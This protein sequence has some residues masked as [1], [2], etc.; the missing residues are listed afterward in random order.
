MDRTRASSSGILLV[1]GFLLL[2]VGA[3]WTAWGFSEQARILPLFVGLPL[4]LMLVIQL[5]RQFSVTVVDEIDGATEARADPAWAPANGLA[6]AR[7]LGWLALAAGAYILLGFY[8]AS[9]VYLLAFLRMHGRLHWRKTAIITVVTLAV[10]AGFFVQA[11][12][13]RVWPGYV[14]ALLG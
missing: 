14:R 3:V 1:S 4:L 10:L 7:A 9:T 6:S 13:I 12:G 8:V 5:I 11:L 2:V